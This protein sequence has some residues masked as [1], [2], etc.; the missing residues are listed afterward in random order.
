MAIT[1]TPVNDAPVALAKSLVIAEDTIGTVTLSATDIDS[2]PPSIFE[3]VSAPNK[4][5]ASLIG[6]TLTFTPDP[7]WNGAT[8]LTYRARDADGAWSAPAT[9]AITVTPVN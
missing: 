8:N 7:D 1:V 5:K 6:S 3:I 2:P 4:G 9:V